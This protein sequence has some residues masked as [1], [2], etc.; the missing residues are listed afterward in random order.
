DKI[1]H[2]LAR[3]LVVAVQE[4]EIH[5]A[6]ETRKVGEA[7]GRRL[8]TLQAGVQDL[9]GVVSEQRSLSLLVQEKCQQ[10]TAETV[11]LQ[12]TDAR[13]DAELCALRAE[14]Q[15]FSATVSER[16]DVLC[17][18]LGVQQEDVTAVKSTLC[19]FSSRVDAV[20]E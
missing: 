3:V 5:I 17:K 14:S 8:D 19:D 7:V 2:G 6:S 1:A 13:Q 18:E 20:V 12:E 4:L 15:D 10:L 16:I 11:Y 9:T